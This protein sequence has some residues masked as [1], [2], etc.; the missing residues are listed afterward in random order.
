LHRTSDEDYLEKDRPRKKQRKIFED[1][2]ARNL[3]EQDRQRLAEQE[4]RRKK[5]QKT[6]ALSDQAGAINKGQ[7]IVNDAKADDQGYVYV[8]PHISSLIKKH[9]I[10]GIRFMWNQIVGDENV[11]QGCLLAH[12]MGL[13]KTMQV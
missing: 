4:E 7:I 12:S 8:H 1:K 2:D 9:Q 5:L 11:M 10:D 6:L 13:G 3:R